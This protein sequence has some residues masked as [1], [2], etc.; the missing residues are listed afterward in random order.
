MLLIVGCGT[1]SRV[2]HVRSSDALESDPRSSV[3]VHVCK[4]ASTRQHGLAL[5]FISRR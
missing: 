4:T 1:R 3:C 5:A 2:L